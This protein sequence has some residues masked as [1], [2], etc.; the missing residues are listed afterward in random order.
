MTECSFAECANPVVG[1]GLCSG[2]YQQQRKGRELSALRKPQRRSVDVLRELAAL[3]TNFCTIWH[4]AVWGNDYPS[5]FL[6]KQQWY[7]HRLVCVWYHGEPPSEHHQAAHGCGRSRCVNP[8]HLRWA[9]PKENNA[10]KIIHGTAP[11]GEDCHQARL[12]NQEAADIRAEYAQGGVTHRELGERYGVHKATIA[13][14][15][16]GKTY[17]ALVGCEQVTR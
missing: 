16:N 15:V 10:D 14:V 1:W 9:T 11:Y 17:R 3:E 4:R 2:H 5:V 7:G 13:L 12:T 8:R 6:G